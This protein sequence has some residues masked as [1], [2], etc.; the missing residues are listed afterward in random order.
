TVIGIYNTSTSLSTFDAYAQGNGP[1][2]YGLYGSG[3]SMSMTRTQFIATS[4]G[5]SGA[6][7]ATASGSGGP[8]TIKI[9]GSTLQG[10]V[11][12][13]TT[14][15]TATTNVF[16]GGS[17]LNGATSVALPSTHTCVL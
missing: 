1:V 13:L 8:Y 16:V 6:G 3:S 7:F 9:D 10:P 12:S 14:G 2:A 17:H 15:G 11:A 5:G 4:G